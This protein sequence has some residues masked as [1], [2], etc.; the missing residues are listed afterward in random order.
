VA[1]SASTLVVGARAKGSYTGAAYVF[2]RSGTVWS[3]QAELTAPDGGPN[4][5]F[6]VSV[7]ISGS[8]AVVGAYG[9]NSYKGAAYVFV[10]AVTTWSQ[11]AELTAA[12]GVGGDE[13]GWSVAFSGSTA[14]V[15][16]HGK[17]GFNGAAYVFVRSGTS[18][19]H[20][21]TEFTPNDSVGVDDFGDSVA[22]SGSTV[23]VGATYN[24]DAGAAYVFVH[25][26]TAWS[27]EAKLTATDGVAS[28]A[29]GKSVA[30]S[31]TTLVA[32]A[33]HKN[34]TTGAAYVFVLP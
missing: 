19:S 12:D 6:G 10:R 33:P 13:F 29:F 3:Q 16:A 1:I 2:V 17:N 20:K 30:L 28:D 23:V 7:A 4:T 34:S 9:L 8:T 25:S 27:L 5:A 18:W 15:G 21:Q 14:L 24:K 31:G 11:Q 26:R 32:G 22:I